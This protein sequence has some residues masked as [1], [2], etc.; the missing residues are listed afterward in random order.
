MAGVMVRVAGVKEGVA[1]LGRV[2]RMK[3]RMDGMKVRV[4]GK[5]MLIPK[6]QREQLLHAPI[7]FPLPCHFQK[8]L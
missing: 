7:L 5:P 1:G 8:G 6:F 4:D 2:A 3:E